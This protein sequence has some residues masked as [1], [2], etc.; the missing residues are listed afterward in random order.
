LDPLSLKSDLVFIDTIKEAMNNIGNV[1]VILG[2]G[3]LD[4]CKMED[5]FFRFELHTALDKGYKLHF[6]LFDASTIE[7]LF[8]RRKTPFLLKLFNKMSTVTCKFVSIDVNFEFVMS[9]L[10]SSV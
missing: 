1:I 3:D 8:S 7:E 6:L 10:A 2:A 9:E 5:D 4:R